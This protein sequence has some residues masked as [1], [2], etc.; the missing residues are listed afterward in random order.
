MELTLISTGLE[1]AARRVPG[2]TEDVAADA[3]LGGD[4]THSV[5]RRP[6]DQSWRHMRPIPASAERSGEV[7]VYLA[8]YPTFAAVDH[9][10]G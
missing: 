1:V 3:R 10:G 8:P 7:P 2:G 4:D 5:C 9:C 6:T